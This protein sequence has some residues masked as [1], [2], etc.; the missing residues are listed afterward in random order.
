MLYIYQEA[1]GSGWELAFN[2]STCFPSSIKINGIELI[3][4][5]KAAKKIEMIVKSDR[6]FAIYTVELL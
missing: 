1:G 6:T 2:Q 4:V 3:K 5:H